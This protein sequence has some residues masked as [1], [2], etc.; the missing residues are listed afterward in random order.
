MSHYPTDLND[1]EWDALHALIPRAHPRGTH[2]ITSMRSVVD[3]ILYRERTRCPWRMLPHD[4]PHWR[5]VYDY[6]SQWHRD[7]TWNQI[8]RALRVVRRESKD[9]QTRGP[10]KKLS[11][12]K[13][14]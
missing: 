7:G 6:H 3:A 10:S 1:R 13:A 8:A 14:A 12:R 5:T 4:F 2:R 11:A 9:R